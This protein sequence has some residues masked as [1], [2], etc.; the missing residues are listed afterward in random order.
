M[1]RDELIT[2]FQDTVDFPKSKE[3][4]KAVRRAVRSTRIYPEG[5]QAKQ[6]D[7]SPIC[8]IVGLIPKVT[9]GAKKSEENGQVIVEENTTFAAAMKYSGG[10]RTAVLNF[11]NPMMPGGG[12]RY[13]AMAQEECLCRSST[14]YMCLTSA[15]AAE[16]Y[17]F[18]RRHSDLLFSDRLIYSQDITVFKDD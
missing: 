8:R 5:F 7:N 17:E 12:V 9:F 14:L 13:G 3:L 6:V 18:H 11:A 1:D 15:N 10:K 4:N 16:Y 2:A